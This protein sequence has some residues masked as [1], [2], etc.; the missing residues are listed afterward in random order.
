MNIYIARALS[1]ISTE[2]M[3]TVQMYLRNIEN[4][5]RKIISQKTNGMKGKSFESS[6]K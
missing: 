6:E 4:E 5:K 3:G 1:Q 2:Y